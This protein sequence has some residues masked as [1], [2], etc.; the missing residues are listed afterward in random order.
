MLKMLSRIFHEFCSSLIS[1]I[2]NNFR[3]DLGVGENRERSSIDTEV[4]N[5]TALSTAE[6]SISLSSEVSL[7]SAVRPLPTLSEFG[8][9]SPVFIRKIDS[10]G[11]WNPEGC[12]TLAER[13][14]AI[15]KKLFKSSERQYSIW[16][17]RQDQ[18]FYGVIA[19]LSAGRSP[20]N[21]DIDF[22]WMTE[23]ELAEVGITLESVTEGDCLQVRELHFNAQIDQASAENL[24]L[25]LLN[26]ER[27]AQRCKKK[28]HI[29]PIL[30]HQKKIGCRATEA[31]QS[32]C[33]CEHG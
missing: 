26:K 12:K 1:L 24:C 20:R 30:E 10:R 5:P 19:S 31:G 33:E 22:I 13:A 15:T 17:V 3:T 14:R 7:G 25:S 4:I 28:P 21:Q 9:D 27:E 18:E 2:N 6:G 32:T 16:L 29:I 11:H 8:I 23:S